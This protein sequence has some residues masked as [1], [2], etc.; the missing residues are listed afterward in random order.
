[1]QVQVNTSIGRIYLDEI[2]G[3]VRI[4]LAVNYSDLNK[5]V[6]CAENA[7]IPGIIGPD[8]DINIGDTVE[9]ICLFAKEAAKYKS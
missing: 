9:E 5:V 4:S 3:I 2:D 6:V 7:G 1:M 8:I